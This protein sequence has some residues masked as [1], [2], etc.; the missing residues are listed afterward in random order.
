MR[1]FPFCIILLEI[2]KLIV[3]S[4]GIPVV[5]FELE[6]ELIINTPAAINGSANILAVN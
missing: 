4:V 6:K 5:L 1:N 3:N 2:V